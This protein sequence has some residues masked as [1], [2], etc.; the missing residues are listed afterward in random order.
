[1]TL[2]HVLPPKQEEVR[3]LALLWSPNL[4]VSVPAVAAAQRTV[5]M[6]PALLGLVPVPALAVIQNQVE[7]ERLLILEPLQPFHSLK[8]L[9]LF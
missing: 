6:N 9:A 8:S 7:D 4:P 3:I 1:M 5:M 2:P